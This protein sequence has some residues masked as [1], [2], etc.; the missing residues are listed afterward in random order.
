MSSHRFNRS[1]RNAGVNTGVNN[2]TYDSTYRYQNNNNRFNRVSDSLK[3][4]VF[5]LPGINNGGLHS[6]H[7]IAYNKEHAIEMI[8][9]QVISDIDKNNRRQNHIN[10]LISTYNT[11]DDYYNFNGVTQQELY[12]NLPNPDNFIGSIASIFGNFSNL[13]QFYQYI[14][15][16][17]NN[18]QLRIYDVTSPCAFYTGERS[19]I[20]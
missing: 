8:A 10:N 2:N 7:A 9:K 17:L 12:N 18:S 6:A 14:F 19:Y 16:L 11:M 4:F 5:Q 3:M 20:N 1:K 13:D 15:N